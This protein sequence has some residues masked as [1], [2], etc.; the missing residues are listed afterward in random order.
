MQ[1]HM[2]WLLQEVIILSTCQWLGDSHNFWLLSQ[3]CCQGANNI[4]RLKLLRQISVYYELEFIIDLLVSNIFA[5]T[6]DIYLF[7]KIFFMNQNPTDWPT[8]RPLILFTNFELFRPIF[9]YLD[10]KTN[11][12]LIWP[13]LNFSWILTWFD[14]FGYCI[15]VRN[16]NIEYY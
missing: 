15:Q 13:M 11:F 4:K 12:D 8:D 1:F 2:I 7:Y 5:R 10:L 16:T 9:T 3:E 6:I 14:L